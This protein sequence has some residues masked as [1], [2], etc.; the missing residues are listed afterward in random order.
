MGFNTS[1]P[2]T[3]EQEPPQSTPASSPFF[4]SSE[5]VGAAY[6]NF[7][8]IP[9]EAADSNKTIAATIIALRLAAH[10][11]ISPACICSSGSMQ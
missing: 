4:K 10:G 2:H 8:K 11:L 3:R 9:N 5:Q 7:Q 6:Q 1:L